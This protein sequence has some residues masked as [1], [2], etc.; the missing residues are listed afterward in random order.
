MAEKK[1][2]RIGLVG[3]GFMGRTHSNAFR[4]APNFF[5]LEHEPVLAAVCARNRH[6]ARKFAKSDERVEISERKG[7]G[8][9]GRTLHVRFLLPTRIEVQG[10]PVYLTNIDD[11]T[12]KLFLKETG[13]N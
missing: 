13:R 4:K 2:L 9:E 11:A 7:G 8:L 10:L 6:R 3:Y 1:P 5:D 12:M